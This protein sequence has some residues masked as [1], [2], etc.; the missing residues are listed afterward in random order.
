MAGDV[1]ERAT[2][3]GTET[4]QAEVIAKLTPAARV[5]LLEQLLEAAQASGALRRAREQ[6][7]RALDAVWGCHRAPVPPKDRDA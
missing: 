7:Q 5:D 2:F 6:K 4:A 1:W 3:A